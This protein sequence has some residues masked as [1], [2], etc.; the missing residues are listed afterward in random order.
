MSQ[1]KDITVYTAQNKKQKAGQCRINHFRTVF[2]FIAAKKASD[3]IIVS[4]VSRN[5]LVKNIHKIEENL[6]ILML[7]DKTLKTSKVTYS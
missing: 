7:I 6:E 1:N 4:K 2:L 5:D 3:A